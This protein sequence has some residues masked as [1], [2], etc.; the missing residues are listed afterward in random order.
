MSEFAEWLDHMDDDAI[1]V[2]MSGRVRA[3][4]TRRYRARLAEELQR[5]DDFIALCESRG[6]RFDSPD[7]VAALDLVG[8]GVRQ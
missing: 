8:F 5:V 1:I 6:W 4:G 3:E 7:E 2:E